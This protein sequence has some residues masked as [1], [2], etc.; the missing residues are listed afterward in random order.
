MKKSV[1]VIL[2]IIVLS[3]AIGIVL[4]P[5][6]P[7]QMASHWNAAG[8]VNGHM[9]KFWGLFL[10][11][12]IS[13]IILGFFLLI[14]KI[15]PLKENIA[16]FR[17]SFDRF[18]VLIELFFFYAYILTIFWNLGIKLN[19]ATAIIPALAVLLYFVGDLVGKSKRNF[20][21]GIRTPWTL[22]NDEVWDKTNKL[23]GRLFKVA[24]I[25]SLAGLIFPN[26]VGLFVVIGLILATALYTVIYS[27][28]IWKKTK[29]I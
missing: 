10:M 29:S 6:M 27:Y 20:F 12:L 8:E 28:I 23:G 16:K 3:F 4:Y 2:L 22:A 25:L 13:I 14:P 18:V 15:D 26:K 1:M 9:S 5:V 19:I 11:P 7:A 21:I 17:G 24:A